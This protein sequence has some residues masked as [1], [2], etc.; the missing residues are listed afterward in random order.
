MS[1]SAAPLGPWVQ[2]SQTHL[3]PRTTAKSLVT[4]IIVRT[5]IAAAPFFVISVGG[6]DYTSRRYK[7]EVALAPMDRRTAHPSKRVTTQKTP[8]SRKP[9]TTMEN[10][11]GTRAE[12][13][14]AP[15]P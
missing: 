12:K 8:P 5:P 7:A 15:A 4:I 11:A 3:D 13:Y 14:P 9:A 1:S 2:A 6:E 10:G